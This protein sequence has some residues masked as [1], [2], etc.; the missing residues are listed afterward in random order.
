[1]FSLSVDVQYEIHPC[2]FHGLRQDQTVPAGHGK[3]LPGM[4]QKY[5]RHI[6]PHQLFQRQP[7]PK[8]C[9]R[10]A[11]VFKTALMGPSPGYCY[12]IAQSQRVWS[13]LLRRAKVC[14]LRAV[15]EGS[16]CTAQMPAS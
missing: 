8:P 16:Q 15:K 6:P 9:I 4:P 10:S 1:M 3:I 14:H 13:K 7:L 11:E 5:R 2:F 12:R